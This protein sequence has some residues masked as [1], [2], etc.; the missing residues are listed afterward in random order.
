MN[1]YVGGHLDIYLSPHRSC[2][3]MELAQPTGLIEILA[4]LGI[5]SEEVTLVVINGQLVELS[6]AIVTNSDDV[7]L[8]P[9]VSGG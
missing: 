6:G 7:K 4:R 2:V 8:F 3:E 1:L 9:S 5:P